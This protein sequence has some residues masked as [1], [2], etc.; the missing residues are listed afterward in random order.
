[1]DAV[2]ITA[3]CS[4]ATLNTIYGFNT[5]K[6]C[7]IIVNGNHF[8]ETKLKDRRIKKSELGS[9]FQSKSIE[10]QGSAGVQGV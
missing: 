2:G 7:I 10:H 6:K 4:D 8:I 9:R 1:L 5:Q 3:V